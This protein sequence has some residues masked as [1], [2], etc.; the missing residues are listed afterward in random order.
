M[1]Q[2]SDGVIWDGVTNPYIPDRES[3]VAIAG[4]YLEFFDETETVDPVL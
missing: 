2:T 3:V 1:S 4:R